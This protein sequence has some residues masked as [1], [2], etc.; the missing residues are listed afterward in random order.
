[1]RAGSA[2]KAGAGSAG[3]PV[4]DNPKN[5]VH[6]V[7]KAFSVLKA[8]DIKLP[9]LTISEVAAR[10]QL[11]RGTAFRLVHTLVHLGYLASVPRGRRFRLTLKCLELGYTP[12]ARANLKELARPMLQA[13]VPDIADAASLGMLDGPDIVYV[14][15]AQ[16]DFP[17]VNIDRRAGSRTGAYAAALGH[18]LLACLPVEQQRD[19]LERSN[20]VRL[21]EKT[22]VDVDAILAR[23][24]V[25]K[26][27]GYALADGEN[28]YGLRTVAAAILDTDGLPIAGV[29]LTIH[30]DRLPMDAFS[31][32][33]VPEVLR[34]AQELTR[35]IRLSFGSIAASR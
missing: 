18:A 33:A 28:A 35:A 26:A 19:L 31:S 10:T 30:A 14:E 32:L 15:R 23:L 7:I 9:E 27:R 8:F 1:M 6:S 29:S 25:V 34:L 2:Q 11:D 24:A 21:S 17:Q 20:R 12:L 3:F 16:I 22:L 13:L 4:E 5:F